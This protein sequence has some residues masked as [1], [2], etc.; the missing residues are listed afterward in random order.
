MK[1]YKYYIVIV[2]LLLCAHTNVWAGNEE[3]AFLDSIAKEVANKRTLFKDIAGVDVAVQQTA[4]YQDKT[5][6]VNC[7]VERAD[8]VDALSVPEIGAML[9]FYCENEPKQT[10]STEAL[11][12]EKYFP[13]FLDAMVKSKSTYRVQTTLTPTGYQDTRALDSQE[14]KQIE[15]VDSTAFKALCLKK[16]TALFNTVLLPFSAKSGN[17]LKGLTAQGDKLWIEILTTDKA[18][19]A[20]EKNMEVIKRA[21]YFCPMIDSEYAKE[22]TKFVDYGFWLTT[23]TGKR[24]E[25]TYTPA[26]RERLD[27][28]TIDATDRQM[29]IILINTMSSL[30]IKMDNYQ[31][32]V[33]FEYQNKTVSMIDEIHTESERVKE[34]LKHQETIKSEYIDHV[35]KAEKL[36]ANFAESKVNIRRVFRGLEGGDVSYMMTAEEIDQ[37]LASPQQVKDS[38]LLQSKMDVRSLQFSMQKC[39]EGY[40]CTRKVSIEGDNVVWSVVANIPLAKY[41]QFVKQD[42]RAKTIEIFKNPA[43]GILRDAVKKLQK[44]LIFRLYSADMKQHHDTTVSYKELEKLGS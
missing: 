13:G 11:L 35:F 30:P 24:M 26:E 10:I 12:M 44:N 8:F 28:M 18:L 7:S 1:R 27:T 38:L 15:R 32:L 40:L 31:T 3:E 14:L 41:K 43:N 33:G 19:T 17:I 22:M 42:L 23:N 37:L 20:M 6:L 2:A 16:G 5:F 36:Y 39:G 34:L 29:F 25:I 9:K 4:S 21:L